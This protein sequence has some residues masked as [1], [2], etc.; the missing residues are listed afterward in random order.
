MGIQ[1]QNYVIATEQPLGYQ[2]G[3]DPVPFFCCSNSCPT[4]IQ[5]SEEY[6]MTTFTVD[7]PIWPLT[8]TIPIIEERLVRDEKTNEFCLPLNST[9]VPK[10]N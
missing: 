2:R 3:N 1:P 8:T 5:E 7:T 9:V 10:V 6:T 4:N